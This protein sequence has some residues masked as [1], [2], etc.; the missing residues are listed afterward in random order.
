MLRPLVLCIV[1]AGHV[2]ATAAPY[3]WSVCP[4]APPGSLSLHNLEIVPAVPRAGC[5]EEFR[6]TGVASQPLLDGTTATADLKFMGMPVPLP[7]A[8]RTFDAC[9][10]FH[11]CPIAASPQE[12][13]FTLGMHMPAQALPCPMGRG[14]TRL[15]CYDLRLQ[16]TDQAGVGA[17]CVQTTFSMEPEGRCTA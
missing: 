8:Q 15:L 13:Q 16:I 11:M 14:G 4:D 10:A 17:A 7:P 5:S 1:L 3:T 12:Q 6:V 9:A 2:A